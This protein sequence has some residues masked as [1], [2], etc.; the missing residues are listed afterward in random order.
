M[1]FLIFLLAVIGSTLII[2]VSFLFKGMRNY[3]KNKNKFLAKFITCSQCTGFWMSL[4]I[5]LIILAHQ[6][7]LFVYYWSDLYYILYG[8]IGSFVCYLTYLLI[9]PLIDRYD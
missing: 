9:K 2:N 5:Q 7:M 4:I 1:D 6:R 3:I 8:F